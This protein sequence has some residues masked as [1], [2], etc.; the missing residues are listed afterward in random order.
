LTGIVDCTLMGVE[1]SRRDVELI[2]VWPPA[3]PGD[4]YLFL[5]WL[6]LLLRLVFVGPGVLRLCLKYALTLKW[7][8]TRIKRLKID[9]LGVIIFN[10]IL[11][12]VLPVSLVL[13][14]RTIFPELGWETW[15]SAPSFGLLLICIGGAAWIIVDFKR[16]LKTRGM[17]KAAR[18][19]RLALTMAAMEIITSTHAVKGWLHN[20]NPLKYH[21]QIRDADALMEGDGEV[22]KRGFFRR[23]GASTADKV[24]EAADSAVRGAESKVEILTD[25]ADEVVEAGINSLI[26]MTFITA[27]RKLAWSI[28]PIVVLVGL[29]TYW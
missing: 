12:M 6:P 3:S 25:A 16:V 27:I 11:A 26:K 15:E 20:L 29:G 28:M 7:F 21:S 19:Q 10:E 2:P 22:K 17:V 13:Y 9:G 14:A 18:K 1:A 4:A 5:V 23:F 24:L 8:W